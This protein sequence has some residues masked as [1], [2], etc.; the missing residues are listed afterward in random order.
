MEGRGIDGRGNMAGR[1]SIVLALFYVAMFTSVHLSTR[2][3]SPAEHP[4]T[5]AT[6]QLPADLEITTRRETALG[7]YFQRERCPLNWSAVERCALKLSQGARDV[8]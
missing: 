5:W 2:H 3:S 6:Y 7:N 4:V 1:L 8:P